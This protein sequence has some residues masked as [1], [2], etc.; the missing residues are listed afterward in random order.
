[1]QQAIN[2]L[3][4]PSPT[5]IPY[6]INPFASL[7]LV[8]TILR[9]IFSPISP[10]LQSQAVGGTFMVQYALHN[11]QRMWSSSPEAVQS[12]K[13]G[14]GSMPYASNALPFYWLARLAERAKQNGTLIVKNTLLSR[15][16][17]EER[18]RTL[19]SW[20]VQINDSLH[21]GVQQMASPNLQSQ[22]QWQT[23]QQQQQTVTVGAP[24]FAHH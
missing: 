4:A 15:V 24:V 1:M 6:T 22:Y 19:K 8:H 12:E 20:F 13:L 21:A 2:A 17:V 16:D 11:W 7:V 18:Y 3:R 5:I 23:Q 10:A 9:D 14:Q